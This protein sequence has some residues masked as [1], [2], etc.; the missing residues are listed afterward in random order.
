VAS[1]LPPP[2]VTEGASDGTGF[3]AERRRSGCLSGCAVVGAVLVI[4]GVLLVWF[5]GATITR[6][7]TSFAGMVREARQVEAAVAS[8]YPSAQVNV[9]IHIH[10]NN[11]AVM[12]IHL[13]GPAFLDDPQVDAAGEARKIAQLAMKTVDDPNGYGEI[14]VMLKRAVPSEGKPAEMEYSFSRKDLVPDRDAPRDD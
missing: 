5:G 11:P 8:A 7:I 14:K 2:V 12:A 10:N 6:W 3:P 13:D 4:G 1:T 9:G